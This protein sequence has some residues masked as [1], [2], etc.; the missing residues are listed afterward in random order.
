MLAA[1]SRHVNQG[2]HCPQV[3][4]YIVRN[5]ATGLLKIGK[6]VDVESRVK[7][8]EIGAG[9]SLELLYTVPVDVESQLHKE[10]SEIRVFG[11]WFTDDGSIRNW[12]TECQQGI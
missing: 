3:S 7:S 12:I 1:S 2:K 8:L 9:T 5:P 11:E 10:F 6:S 4:T